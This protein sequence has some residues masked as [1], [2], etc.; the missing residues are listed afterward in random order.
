MLSHAKQ[1]I[2]DLTRKIAPLK[3]ILSE[4]QMALYLEKN[5]LLKQVFDDK[6]AELLAT[7]KKRAWLVSKKMRETIKKQAL[8]Y[9]FNIIKNNIAA[10]EDTQRTLQMCLRTA[11]T[12]ASKKTPAIQHA[13]DFLGHDTIRYIF[14]FAGN[15]ASLSATNKLFCDVVNSR[16]FWQQRLQGAFAIPLAYLAYIPH[17]HNPARSV[18]NVRAVHQRLLH[19]SRNRPQS[20]LFY[21]ALI[22]SC[23]DFPPLTVS[24]APFP[25]LQT[26][27][28]LI[29]FHEAVQLNNMGLA[30]HILEEIF[31]KKM[32]FE[33]HVDGIFPYDTSNFIYPDCLA[34]QLAAQK[35][36][37]VLLKSM[38]QQLSNCY[39]SLSIIAKEK[40]NSALRVLRHQSQPPEQLLTDAEAAAYVNDL[41][42]NEEFE[43]AHQML[44]TG[45]NPDIKMLE[46]A[47]QDHSNNSDANRKLLLH[48]IE[49]TETHSSLLRDISQLN[50]TVF[51]AWFHQLHRGDI[52]NIELL[53]KFYEIL[54]KSDFFEIV[55]KSRSSYLTDIQSSVENAIKDT[56]EGVEK[57][58][59]APTIE[60]LKSDKEQNGFA[61]D[62]THLKDSIKNSD[63]ALIATIMTRPEFPSWFSQLDNDGKNAL[64]NLVVSK[65]PLAID[66]ISI[67]N[68]VTL[69]MQPPHNT[70]L[71]LSQDVKI[72]VFSQALFHQD[73][74]LARLFLKQENTILQT[75]SSWDDI[76][77][78]SQLHQAGP[79]MLAWLED[80]LNAAI[81]REILMSISDDFADHVLDCMEINHTKHVV[82]FETRLV[83]LLLFLNAVTRCREQIIQ[84][85]AVAQISPSEKT[86]PTTVPEEKKTTVSIKGLDEQT[87]TYSPKLFSMPSFSPDRKSLMEIIRRMHHD[88]ERLFQKPQE[89]PDFNHAAQQ[90]KMDIAFLDS[91]IGKSEVGSAVISLRHLQRLQRNIADITKY[92]S[93]SSSATLANQLATCCQAL[94]LREEQ[95][96]QAQKAISTP[97]M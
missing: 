50:S 7:Y 81:P 68:L 4:K 64:I 56:Q 55:R 27:M 24:E 69:I 12:E 46:N 67:K 84:D 57:A 74:A 96:V 9:V 63:H 58:T 75:F 89:N 10:H 19:L 85:K 28:L 88:A 82:R 94:Q 31:I 79:Q 39:P 66:P 71:T 93:Q 70:E 61:L 25:A 44:Q 87:T 73:K 16:A 22:D 41:I 86:I 60:T 8:N 48:L 17:H 92:L 11:T 47:M 2:D 13:F 59:E 34:I 95:Q 29:Y 38:Q 76:D 42:L 26:K 90:I 91:Q 21:R 49:L 40:I 77:E 78:V 36:H 97:K 3:V 14:T 53:K 23:I 80:E 32:T 20:H 37:T 1:Q 15:V 18:A 65:R 51:E 30:L 45:V 72:K 52:K 54:R 5:D 6:K 83:I 43:L 33:N 35:K 62:I